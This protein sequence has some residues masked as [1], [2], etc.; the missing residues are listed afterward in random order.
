MA[1]ISKKHR[2]N[3]N[4]TMLTRY[5][6]TYRDIY[7]KQ[8]TAGCYKTKA[9]AQAH[10]AEFDCINPDIEEITFEQMFT[11]FKE[12]VLPRYSHT[13]QTTYKLYMDKH[14]SK[15]YPMKY[16]K[17]TS[18]ALQQFI[19]E[20][21]TNNSPYV[22]ELC[23][24]I[25]NS[26]CNYA[27]KHK[28]IKENKFLA[29]EKV[30]VSPQ[31][32]YH[33]TEAQEKDVLKCC[34]KLYPKYYALLYTLMGTG[35]R[36]GEVLALDIADLDVENKCFKVNKQYT[37]GKLKLGTKNP[38]RKVKML[39]RRVYIA[40]DVVKVLQEHIKTLPTGTT[41]LFPSKVNKYINVENFR[42]RVWKPLLIYAGITDRVRLHDLRGSYAD[43][44][45]TRT[46]NIKFIQNQLGH[47]KS[48]T[49]LDIYTQNS[50]DMVD[51][52]LG[53]M[54]DILNGDC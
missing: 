52:A 16:K 51:K 8:H 26:V 32:K 41:L 18:I 20:I 24:K 48:Q 33:L 5:V 6:I 31:D 11:L 4:G 44:A 25:A 19:N 1:G 39:S 28:L 3:K 21:E 43:I 27:I 42:S 12:T 23:L 37:K 2:R 40:K 22:A 45:L 46:A 15:L 35:M 53:S 10:L 34:K 36:I 54:D 47:R 13:T 17:T 50:Q 7:G 49:T 30:I 29:V 14:L 9:E 38:A